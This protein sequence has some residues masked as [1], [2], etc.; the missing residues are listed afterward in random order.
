MVKQFSI[1]PK[2]ILPTAGSL[3][4]APTQ[5]IYYV[6]RFVNI[7]KLN[8][9]IFTIYHEEDAAERVL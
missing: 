9:Y 6:A 1:E 7:I 3:Y 2:K 8:F 4:F 5:S